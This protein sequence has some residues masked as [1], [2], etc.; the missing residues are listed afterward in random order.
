MADP[1]YSSLSTTV[2]AVGNCRIAI[3]IYAKAGFI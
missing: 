2:D 3:N 1:G